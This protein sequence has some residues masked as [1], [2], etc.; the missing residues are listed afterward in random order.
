M[1]GET[2]DGAY[3]DGSRRRPQRRASSRAPAESAVSRPRGI[4]RQHPETVTREPPRV[5]LE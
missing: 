4:G 5:R 1:A 3:H 2:T